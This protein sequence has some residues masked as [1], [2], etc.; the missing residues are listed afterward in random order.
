MTSQLQPGRPSKEHIEAGDWVGCL[1]EIR[2]GP[3][4]GQAKP[5]KVCSPA[6]VNEQA[7]S[8]STLQEGPSLWVLC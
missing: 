5:G 6:L 4:P 8:L 2:D 1:Y 3:T 7:E